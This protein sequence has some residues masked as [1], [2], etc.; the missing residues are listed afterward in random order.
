MLS[1]GAHCEDSTCQI[2]WISRHYLFRLE[3]KCPSFEIEIKKY[4]IRQLLSTQ[5]SLISNYFSLPM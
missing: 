4:D 1:G 5:I 3:K 2:N